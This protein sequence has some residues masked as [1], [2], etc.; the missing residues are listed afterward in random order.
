MY[1]PSWCEEFQRLNKGSLASLDLEQ[2]DLTFKRCAWVFADA[3]KRCVRGGKMVFSTDGCFL[4]PRAG[5]DGQL[6]TLSGIDASARSVAISYAI[7]SVE[8]A[9][10]YQWFLELTSAVQVD[11][12]ADGIAAVTLKMYLDVNTT[13]VFSDRGGCAGGWLF[14]PHDLMSIC[15]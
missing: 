15:L 7:V 13:V 4:K 5:F 10:N 1:I 11:V 14:N 2:D 8:N 6:L 3:A 9:D 12:A